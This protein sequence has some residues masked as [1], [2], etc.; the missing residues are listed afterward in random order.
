MAKIR[1]VAMM[2]KDPK[3]LRDYYV[4]GF[5]FEQCYES[6]TG[7]VMVTDGL[8]NLALLQIRGGDSDVVGTHRA[9]GGEANQQPGINHFGF[10]VDSIDGALER[11]GGGLKYGENPQDG[12]PAEMRVV[13]PWGNNFDLSSRGFFGREEKRVPGIRQVIVQADD[14]AAVAAF[15]RDK[16][17]LQAEGSGP[18]GAV[19]LGD[20]HVHLSVVPQGLTQKRGI[21]AIGIQVDDW[22]ALRE[23]F[24]AMG[25]TLPPAA[26]A[27]A[28]V[29]VRDPEGNILVLSVTAF[30]RAPQPVASSARS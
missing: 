22:A 2:V 18:D 11:I 8:F 6:K 16:L 12:R 9:D 3:A 7:S 5:G 20:G 25:Q 4:Q 17:E 15:F 29:V 26:S 24:A 21:Q 13:D 1:H 27:A 28:E 30:D 19:A 10:V 14:P 23:R